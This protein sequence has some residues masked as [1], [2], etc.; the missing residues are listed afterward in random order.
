MELTSLVGFIL[1]PL[2]DLI[3]KR[4]AD[5]KV[6]F[7]VSVSVCLGIGVLQNLS[8]LKAGDVSELLSSFAVIFTTAQLTYKLYWEKSDFRASVMK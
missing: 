7:L 3:N 5:S 2:I 8:S 6:R 1:P 4:V